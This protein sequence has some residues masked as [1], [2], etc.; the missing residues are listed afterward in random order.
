V[1]P[2]DG[3]QQVLGASERY[4]DIFNAAADAMALRDA[5]F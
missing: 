1:L 5:D 4:R 3:L 2:V